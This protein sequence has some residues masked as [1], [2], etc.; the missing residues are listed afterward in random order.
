MAPTAYRAILAVSSVLSI[1]GATFILQSVL[2][3]EKRNTAQWLMLVN[4]FFNAFACVGFLL[5]VFAHQPAAGEALS[6]NCIS[7][8]LGI[9]FFN[10]CSVFWTSSLALNH[11]LWVVKARSELDRLRLLKYYLVASLTL[12]SILTIILSSRGKL[13]W[14]ELYCWTPD[15]NYQ[16][17][18][19]YLWVLLAVSFNLLC[20]VR[21][22]I[23][24]HKKKGN[25]NRQLEAHVALLDKRSN[26]YICAFIIVWLPGLLNR[27]LIGQFG[28]E[29]LLG[30]EVLFVPLQGFINALIY[31]RTWGR[32]GRFL[33]CCRKQDF[34]GRA[35]DFDLE[36]LAKLDNCIQLSEKTIFFSTFNMGEKDMTAKGIA[37]WIPSG[38]TYDIYVV[39]VQEC[40]HPERLRRKIQKHL[41]DQ[42]SKPQDAPQ[43][44]QQTLFSHHTIDAT[45]TKDGNR[46]VGQAEKRRPLDEERG[47]E[48]YY[49]CFSEQI[50]SDVHQLGYHGYISLF[51]FVDRHYVDAGVFNVKEHEAAKRG[52]DLLLTRASNKGAVGLSFQFYNT[53]IA[54]VT[55]HFCSDKK[56]AN[57]IENRIQDGQEIIKTLNFEHASSHWDFP[58]TQHHCFFLGDFNFRSCLEPEQ[59][60]EAI[61]DASADNT[62]ESWWDYFVKFD[63]LLYARSRG[64]IFHG[65]EESPLAFL[66]SF[67]RK[68]GK[69]GQITDASSVEALAAA[70]STTVTESDGKET[71]RTPCH[72]DRLLWTSLPDLRQRVDCV[73]YYSPENVRISDHNPV[74]ALFNI[75]INTG[76]QLKNEHEKRLNQLDRNSLQA[77]RV[78]LT[79]LSLSPTCEPAD[80]LKGQQSEWYIP[81]GAKVDGKKLGRCEALKADHVTHI[82]AAFPLLSEDPEQGVV[83]HLS[84]LPS[85]HL[86]KRQTWTKATKEGLTM[87]RAASWVHGLHMLVKLTGKDDV[88]VGQGVICL[89]EDAVRR[90][91]LAGTDHTESRTLWDEVQGAHSM[92]ETFAM[93][94]SF[95][96]VDDLVVR[97]CPFETALTHGGQLV[98][99]LEGK[100][101]LELVRG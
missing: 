3:L 67:R 50:G 83:D 42:R 17:F 100:M 56:G 77:W 84:G 71:S 24:L 34:L 49:K 85:R 23:K 35:R 95:K 9:H 65:W 4:S 79:R 51:V 69:E 45:K 101:V 14:A 15:G 18:T 31:G 2:R 90:N 54:F 37:K 7:Q 22:S 48:G 30:A 68:R 97:E 91:L 11:Y 6:A 60:L 80:I 25:R 61:T 12:S 8:A 63:E 38:S 20:F 62:P 92:R 74:V 13:G 36:S 76:I 70:F 82:V 87:E 73:A 57:R 1:L 47:V 64:L 53:S 98:G 52:K 26:M 5:S 93:M 16:F 32:V 99:R 27:L 41:D 89:Q 46:L 28:S 96:K 43:G 33:C 55:G 10:L 39:G 29:A 75:D 78:T 59:A 58:D 94:T 72:T 19:F 81:E 40:M 88:C 86:A 44:G 66:P 21:S